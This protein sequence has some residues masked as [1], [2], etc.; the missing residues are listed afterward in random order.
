MLFDCLSF[1]RVSV[2]VLGGG[3]AVI[4]FRLFFG[5]EVVLF[6]CFVC[7]CAVV[8]YVLFVFDL[9]VFVVR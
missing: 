6:S 9:L 1:C 2:C 5:G 8:V 7:L 4:M 3:V